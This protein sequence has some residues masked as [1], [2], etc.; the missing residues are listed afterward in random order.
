MAA[1]DLNDSILVTVNGTLLGQRTMNTFWYRVHEITGDPQET[2]AFQAL[3]AE[4]S[5]PGKLLANYLKCVPTNWKGYQVWFQAIKPLRQ[6]KVA[7]PWVIDGEGVGSALTA[8]V[9][10]SIT[11]LGDTAAR[12]AVGGIRIPI[13][14]GTQFLTDGKLTIDQLAAMADLAGEM[15]VD[16]ATGVPAVTYR[17]MVGKPDNAGNYWRVVDTLVQPEA[18]VMRRRT[19]GRGI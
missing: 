6:R 10:G 15:S 18:R 17:P 11:R 9:Q 16:Y 8:N 4:M 5:S 2:I 1:L 19:V 12:E 14:T 3:F 13:G 7:F